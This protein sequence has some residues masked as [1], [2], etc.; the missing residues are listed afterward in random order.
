M[1][2]GPFV[3][4][5]ELVSENLARNLLLSFSLFSYLAEHASADHEEE[6]R[7]VKSSSDRGGTTRA[8]RRAKRGDRK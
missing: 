3:L 1:I 4:L 7:A 8:D 6:F 5:L 2:D